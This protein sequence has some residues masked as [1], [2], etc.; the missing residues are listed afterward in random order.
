[1]NLKTNSKKVYHIENILW[2]PYFR[3]NNRD[4]NIKQDCYIARSP[5]KKTNEENITLLT[6]ALLSGEITCNMLTFSADSIAFPNKD[7][8]VWKILR[9]E[10]R[11]FQLQVAC[12]HISALQYFRGAGVTPNIF[13]FSNIDCSFKEVEVIDSYCKRDSI[14]LI[15]NI[16]TTDTLIYPRVDIFHPILRKPILGE[17]LK[18]KAY[19]EYIKLEN[20]CK[21]I[22]QRTSKDSC[23]FHAE[24]SDKK[25]CS[26]GINMIH[27]W[28]TGTATKCPYDS[29]HLADPNSVGSNIIQNIKNCLD[30]REYHPW[31]YCKIRNN[32]RR[33]YNGE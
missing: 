27:V 19:E 29:N 2:Q 6:N 22:T 5:Y 15:H 13:A 30:D 24:Q 21:G 17:E 1:M 4:C 8:A 25:S 3:C 16:I 20:L 11:P 18:L 10:D 23:V 7:S 31:N 9:S 26:A 32:I 28:P 12:A 14:K 33:Y